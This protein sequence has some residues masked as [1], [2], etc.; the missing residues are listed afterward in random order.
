MQRSIVSLQMLCGGRQHVRAER[1]SC[2]GLGRI[3]ECCPSVTVSWSIAARCRL[4][5]Q[6]SPHPLSS[7]TM[8][9][10]FLVSCRSVVFPSCLL[11]SRSNYLR[12]SAPVCS[13]PASL[14]LTDAEVAAVSCS[15]W[16]SVCIS[17][18]HRHCH[19]PAC[20]YYLESRIQRIHID[21]KPTMAWCVV[22][23]LR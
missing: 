21:H 13:V 5:T 1:N 14:R 12:S 16:H 2:S 6:Q 9:T 7:V 15:G 10:F 17:S 23:V 19:T 8:P 18:C 11:E 22:G 20:S 4:Q 3:V